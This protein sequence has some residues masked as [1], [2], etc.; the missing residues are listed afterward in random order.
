MFNHMNRDF[1]NHKTLIYINYYRNTRSYL[2]TTFIASFGKLKLHVLVYLF[3]IMISHV[4]L[5]LSVKP[6]YNKIGVVYW[7]VMR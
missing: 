6:V 4:V 5:N 2:A 1:S 3:F 7:L